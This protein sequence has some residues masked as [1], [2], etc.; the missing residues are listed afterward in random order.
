MEGDAIE[1]EGVVEENAH[2]GKGAERF[3][4]ND[5]RV[6]RGGVEE[7]EQGE[8]DTELELGGGRKPHTHKVV[9]QWLAKELSNDQHPRG[10][11][12]DQ[13]DVNKEVNPIQVEPIPPYTN[14]QP[15]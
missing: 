15:S 10:V 4:K 12:K 1:N 11:T 14:F 5:K 2:S 8:A 9:A 6:R 13:I 7:G 3:W